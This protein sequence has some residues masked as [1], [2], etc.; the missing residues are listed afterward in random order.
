MTNEYIVNRF[1]LD[2]CR[3]RPQINAFAMDGV[4]CCAEIQSVFNDESNLIAFVAGSFAE[5]YIEPMLTC[6]GDIDVMFYR[7][8]QLAIPRGHAPPTQLPDEFHDY[9]Q[10]CEII[11]SHF[12]GY[13]YLE[14][15][16]LL[17]E[18][19]DDQ[20]YNCVEYDRWTYLTNE[21]LHTI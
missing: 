16:Y 21:L 1:L 14:L 2:T 15:R 19:T 12:P 7:G 8:T 11:D 4:Q 18:C 10:V 9:V 17:T 3:P 13:V 5:F 20:T 6:I